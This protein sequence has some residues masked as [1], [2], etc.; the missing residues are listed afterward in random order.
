MKEN[1][2]YKYH[3]EVQI[4]FS[5]L[6]S[7]TA[8]DGTQTSSYE[9]RLMEPWF[10]TETKQVLYKNQIHDL[11]QKDFQSILAK[12]D[13]FLHQGSGWTFERIL[14]L[15]LTIAEFVP[16]SGGKISRPHA[17]LPTSIRKKRACLHTRIEYADDDKCFL[18]CIAVHEK[19]NNG[20]NDFRKFNL[21]KWEMKTTL[22]LSNLSYPTSLRQ[23]SLFEQRNNY[24]IN[25]Y[26]WTAASKEQK[27]VPLQVLYLSK[28]VRTAPK[29]NHVDLLL[30][31]NHYFLITNLSRLIGNDI[32]RRCGKKFVC[33]SCLTLYSTEAKKRAHDR[34]CLNSGQVYRFPANNMLKFNK[35]SSMCKRRHVIYYDFETY[36]EKDPSSPGLVRHVPIAVAGKRICSNK[37]Y[38]S[39][40]FIHVGVDCIQK[41]LFWLNEMIDECYIID[42]HHAKT[43]C[44]MTEADWNRFH[45]QKNCEMCQCSFSDSTKKCVDHDH[46][47]GT[48]RFG[49]CDR[50][51]LTY[52]AER[53]LSISCFAHNATRYD[54]HLFVEEL[55]KANEASGNN[56]FRILPKNTEHFLAIYS[57]SLVFLDSYQFLASSLADLVEMMKKD[58]SIHG[59]SA[60]TA[61]SFLL[62]YEYLNEDKDKYNLLVRKG[63]FC[64]EYLDSPSK[65]EETSLPPISSFY[66]TLRKQTVSSEDYAHAQLVWK[67]MNCRTLEDYLKVYLET[68]VLLLADCYEMFRSMSLKHFVLDPAKFISTPHLAFNA[69]LKMTNIEL[70]LFQDLEMYFFVKKGIRGGIASIVLRHV[71]NLNFPQMKE[72][73]SPDL[74]RREILA[75][76]AT[77]LYGYALSQPLPTGNYHWVEHVDKFDI[78]SMISST[79][80]NFGYILEVD[81]DY[82]SEIHD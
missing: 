74:P 57:D 59:N 21:H 24:S 28:N 38:N 79:N 3:F 19:Y 78:A 45:A 41:F 15:R 52:G 43:Y 49:L 76:D 23:I 16:F 68:D 67:T 51:N 64:Y 1:S 34:C 35:Y 58:V 72:L 8:D 82:P 29:R 11:L 77:N 50:C 71:D 36:L 39:D 75:L 60:N 25:V 6:V 18:Y 4:Q 69:M 54:N 26:R 17:L 63:I 56:K 44:N 20:C 7:T 37:E 5:K 12:T 40:L 2:G 65:L 31:D 62:L 73:F 66:D 80:S 81:L 48:F 9:K 70:E 22:D 14:D 10:T 61:S 42:L 46:L 13:T 33:R 32:K 55:A 47:L 53:E 30:H 27:T